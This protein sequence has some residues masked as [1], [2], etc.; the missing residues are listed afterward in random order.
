MNAYIFP[1]QGS[2]YKGMGKSLFD[3]FPEYVEQAN[4]ILGYSITELCMENPDKK[5]SLTQFTQPAL[6]VVNV[7][8]YLQKVRGAGVKPIC[9][10]G[11]SLG[12]YN[13]LFA[14]GAF[15]FLTGL[16]M[17][18]TRGTLMARADSGGMVAVIGLKADKIQQLCQGFDSSEVQIANYNSPSQVVI[19]G[20]LVALEEVQK[21]LNSAGAHCIPLNV[22]AAFH[23]KHMHAASLEFADCLEKI[24]FKPLHLPVIANIT[25]QPYPQDSI[26][27]YL[28]KQ[29]TG[30][31]QWNDTIR[32]I[33]GFGNIDIEEVGPGNVLT[34][35]SIKIR[36]EAKPIRS[37]QSEILHK[38]QSIPKKPAVQKIVIQS[39]AALGCKRFKQ[40]YGL[41]YAYLAGSMYRGI[42]S[43]EIVVKMGQSGM[44]AFLGTQ[45]QPLP[46]IER[47]LRFIQHQLCRGEA[48]GINLFHSRHTAQESALVELILRN[49]ITIVEATGY[50]QN[51]SLELVYYRLKGLQQ[52]DDGRIVAK[53]KII[54]KLTRPEVATAFL[55]P[56]PEK[57]VQQLLSEKRITEQQAQYAK[58]VPMADD[59]CVVADSGGYTD[60]G[61]ASVMIPTICR[62]RDK[63]LSQFKYTNTIGVGAAGGIGTPEAALSAF[64]LGADF[65]VTGSINQCTVEAG[66]S[67][68]VKDLLQSMNIQ[69]T[70]YARVD[71]VF[72]VGG[73]IQVLK[74]GGFFSTRVNTLADIYARYESLDAI[75][76][77]TQEYLQDKFFG[78]CFE[79]VY[80]ELKD[81]E[82]KHKPEVIERAETFPKYK[83]AL[84][85]HWYFV[86]A[87]K[88]AIDGNEERKVDFQIMT[89]P[90]LGAFN[91]WV[92]DTDLKYWKNRKVD[93][94]A[95]KLLA[96]T[97]ELLSHSTKRLMTALPY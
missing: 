67:D 66:T 62:L 45:G 39:A 58:Q 27:E 68:V 87:S 78:M 54:A 33:Q 38:A 1:G 59:L 31:V 44:L 93:E 24:E 82:Y 7:L 51:L 50:L 52:A 41:D 17:V 3:L 35:L 73:H 30:A 72:D 91:Q 53:N 94:I 49:N 65:I 79:D 13:A 71:E 75:D 97:A 32:Y 15:D 63:I 10:A 28:V 74:K 46:D 40:S 88:W 57:I 42:S 60:K 21:A 95:T 6:Y 34:K 64:I 48:Y 8:S 37:N 9:V 84:L 18:K 11:H 5:L 86:N 89:G 56:A 81:K 76:A 90:A 26:K 4:D 36:K 61:V 25:A 19:S 80:R 12:E 47:D 23:S 14:A 70:D 55:S 20:N 22:S 69:D 29:I 43:K 83:M 77:E 92:K 2:Q 96:E 85:F 16:K